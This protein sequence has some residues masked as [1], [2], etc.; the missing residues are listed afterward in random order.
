M[1]V[2]LKCHV[3]MP[4]AS[5]AQNFLE[6]FSSGQN[7]AKFAPLKIKPIPTTVFDSTL[8][9]LF[10]PPSSIAFTLFFIAIAVAG[11]NRGGKGIYADACF[12]M[13]MVFL[14][15]FTLNI[16]S[17]YTHAY[18]S[19]SPE[20]YAI[21]FIP[22]MG[23]EVLMSSFFVLYLFHRNDLIKWIV[24]LGALTLFPLFLINIALSANHIRLYGSWSASLNQLVNT[25]FGQSQLWIQPC[26]FILIVAA[27]Y[28]AIIAC[29]HTYRKQITSYFS[30]D[31]CK[32]HNILIV[33]AIGYLIY[34]GIMVL[35]VIEFCGIDLNSRIAMPY[36]SIYAKTI[37]F[38]FFVYIIIRFANHYHNLEPALYT[39]KEIENETLKR[40]E[41]KSL[42]GENDDLIAEF[43]TTT[44]K[45]TFKKLPAQP[46]A[47]LMKQLLE[48]WQDNPKKFYLRNDINLLQVANMLQIRPR[49][50]SEYL[51]L[52]WGVNFNQYINNLRIDEAKRLILKNPS[53]SFTDIAFATGFSSVASFSKT[54]KRITGLS[55]SQFRNK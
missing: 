49:F 7:W 15:D 19:S 25:R 16:S 52:V 28:I 30:F 42:K 55:P 44:S 14:F 5:Y 50:L 26:L 47:P 13:A 39:I 43:T 53:R 10:L 2:F 48:K 3:C 45:R 31:E 21:V 46:D 33:A 32:H 54:F 4:S 9:L 22:I 20:S 35:G 11:A 12:M 17:F 1:V 29:F 51:N 18:T 41:I 6:I 34:I 8:V 36:V 37:F 23:I 24:C 40:G 38:V 27:C